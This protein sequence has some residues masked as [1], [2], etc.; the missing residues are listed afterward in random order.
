MPHFVDFVL[1][2]INFSQ[3][4]TCFKRKLVETS[5]DESDGSSLIMYLGL[6]CFKSRKIIIVICLI[7][8]NLLVMKVKK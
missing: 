8:R 6:K 2:Y 4:S 3:S 5:K 1:V 7:R